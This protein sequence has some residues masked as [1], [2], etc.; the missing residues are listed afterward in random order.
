M[1]MMMMW[2]KENVFSWN[3]AENPKQAI[4][5]IRTQGSSSSQGSL[6]ILITRN[7]SQG[8]GERERV[9]PR[10]TFLVVRSKERQLY[11]QAIPS[12]ACALYCNSYSV[13]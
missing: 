9:F 5:L 4:W 3:K 11:P 2:P 8:E 12:L 1:M 10:K 6:L 7:V 13:L